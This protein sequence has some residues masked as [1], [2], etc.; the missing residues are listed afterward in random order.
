MVTAMETLQHPVHHVSMH[1][2]GD[3]FHPEESDRTEKEWGKELH[4]GALR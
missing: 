3:E 1:H 4:H 2:I